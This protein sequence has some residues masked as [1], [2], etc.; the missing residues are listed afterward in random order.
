MANIMLCI[1]H[2]FVTCVLPSESPRNKQTCGL[3]AENPLSREKL[4]GSHQQ[5]ERFQISLP[6]RG[7]CSF[8]RMLQFVYKSLMGTLGQNY[9]FSVFLCD[10]KR[11]INLMRALV[12]GNYLPIIA[13][14]IQILVSSE[15][16][17]YHGCDQV[18]C[19]PL[20]HSDDAWHYSGCFVQSL[21]ALSTLQ[22][23][24]MYNERCVAL[25]VLLI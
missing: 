7:V 9:G 6:Q 22:V 12:K 2:V 16:S 17:I 14:T 5:S 20:L 3:T 23:S 11:C 19:T 10:K 24:C 4:S 25:H 18:L 21:S 15:R 13:A 1:N 8:R